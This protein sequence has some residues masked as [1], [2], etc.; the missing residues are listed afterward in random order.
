M[1]HAD[2][3]PNKKKV[4]VTSSKDLFKAKQGSLW[5]ENQGKYTGQTG[6]VELEYPNGD[7]AVSF[8]DGEWLRIDAAAVTQL[9]TIPEKV[10]PSTGTSLAPELIS[11]VSLSGGSFLGIETKKVSE[12]LL[13]TSINE[14]SPCRHLQVN[15][16][17]TLVDGRTIQTQA[18]LLRAIEVGDTVRGYSTVTTKGLP[19]SPKEVS[20]SIIRAASL[21]PGATL[22]DIN[23]LLEEAE[24]RIEDYN[25]MILL[26]ASEIEKIRALAAEKKGQDSKPADTKEEK[27]KEE[28]PTDV[29]A[30]NNNNNNNNSSKT[31]TTDETTTEK[32]K[33]KSKKIIIAKEME[34][35]EVLEAFT[36]MHHGRRRDDAEKRLQVTGKPDLE[37]LEF[38]DLRA[39]AEDL[40]TG[41]DQ[42]ALEVFY[43]GEME[44]AGDLNTFKVNMIEKLAR[45][46]ISGIV[47]PITPKEAGCMYPLIGIPIII[48]W[49]QALRFGN[50]VFHDF[51]TEQIDPKEHG[52]EGGGDGK[53]GGCAQQ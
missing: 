9:E 2:P 5:E 11:K 7:I 18:E 37:D 33:K 51:G 45:R 14:D 42:L 1:P 39:C 19:H 34:K 35:S 22:S 28:T 52:A 46:G 40:P 24:T 15:H 4:T 20:H 36:K 3:S 27:E 12:G 25:N 10:K 44:D 8:S 29:P 23:K 53:K 26:Q 13:I 17:I 6:Q 16:V 41:D 30:D 47:A 43:F 38:W 48:P 31:S 49:K 21:K 32:K 50:L